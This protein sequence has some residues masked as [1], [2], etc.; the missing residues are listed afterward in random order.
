MLGVRVYW[1]EIDD[2]EAALGEPESLKKAALQFRQVLREV[3]AVTTPI[4]SASL[5]CS[6][7]SMCWSSIS[8][9]NRSCIAM[10]WLGSMARCNTRLSDLVR[11]A[12]DRLGHSRQWSRI[13]QATA[14]G[15]GPRGRCREQAEERDRGFSSRVARAAGSQEPSLVR[16]GTP[17]RSRALHRLAAK[18][19]S[20]AGSSFAPE[21]AVAAQRVR[22]APDSER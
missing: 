1:S 13:S 17:R 14:G 22:P 12:A 16:A 6:R 3:L 4:P 19:R 21:R 20:V 15:A 9:P 10:R 11:R 8:F 7:A 18:R 5:L 2:P